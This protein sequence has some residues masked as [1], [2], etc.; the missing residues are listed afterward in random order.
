MYGPRDPTRITGLPLSKEDVVYKARHICQTSMPLDWEWGKIPLSTSNP[1]SDEVR[2][3]VIRVVLP[4]A[5]TL[6]LTVFPFF[7]RR[8][9]VFLA[10]LR[11]SEALPASELWTLRTRILTF[12]GR[13]SRW[14]ARTPRAP[15]TFPTKTPA[16]MMK[17]SYSRYLAFSLPHR[18][19][20]C[21]CPLSQHQPAGPGTCGS[22]S[23]R[24]WP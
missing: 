10:S 18:L 6:R 14:A 12:I 1:P 4:A 15:V 17:L 5:F 11:R 22:A 24:G 3:C 7:Y 9:S 19:S 16:R 21:R 13:T 2:N 23:G 20:F 8:R